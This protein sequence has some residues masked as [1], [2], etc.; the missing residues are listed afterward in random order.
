MQQ[1]EGDDG[2]HNEE[3]ASVEA[4]GRQ[5]RNQQRQQQQRC[6]KERQVDAPSLGFGI[7]PVD[8]LA[9]FGLH[10]RPACADRVSRSLWKTRSAVLAGPNAIDKQEFNRGTTGEP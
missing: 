5:S 1:E 7:K 4:L 8:E 3:Q 10:K 2:K 6:E 9:E